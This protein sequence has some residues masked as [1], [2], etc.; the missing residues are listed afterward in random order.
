MNRGVLYY[1]MIPLVIIAGLLQSTAA[2]R[3]EI[4]AVKPDLVLL[5]VLIGTLI[6]GSRP[7]IVW[8]F[9]GGLAMDVFSGGPMGASSLALMMAAL[10]GG[11]GHRTFSRYNL[12]VPVGATVAGT[13]VYSATYLAILVVLSYFRLTMHNPP[14]WATLQFIVVPALVYNTTLMLLVMPLLNRIPESQ[15]I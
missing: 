14:I 10:L 2:G 1:L 9:I 13:F 7:G 15:D 8:A 5:L 4:Q 3:I 12:L 6:Y 11:L